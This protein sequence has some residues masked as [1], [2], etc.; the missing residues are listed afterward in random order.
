METWV[1]IVIVIVVIAVVV[2][3]VLWSQRRS[4][5]R[6]TERIEK[7]QDLRTQGQEADLRA[8]EEAAVAARQQA[9][10]QRARM[11]AERLEEA[12]AER[13]AEAQRAQQDAQ[14]RLAEADRLVPEGTDLDGRT[15]VRRAADRADE[16]VVGEDPGVREDRRP[17]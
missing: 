5:H 3:V 1:W 17:T 9:E 13:A 8:K 7:A 4:D 10:A 6:A 14:A 12:A 2:G 15:D 11:D 16:R